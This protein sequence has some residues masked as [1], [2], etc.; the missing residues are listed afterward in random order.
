MLDTIREVATP[1]GCTLSLRLAGPVTRASAWLLDFVIRSFLF[2]AIMESLAVA[3]IASGAGGVLI[4]FV[5]EWIYPV[6]FEVYWRG[7]TPGKKVCN[8]LVLLDDGTPVG[9][10][11]SVVRNMLRAVD[12][13]PFLYGLGLISMLLNRDFK[14]LGDLAAGTIVVY[15]DDPPKLP[16]ADPYAVA[17]PSPVLLTLS[18]QRAIIEFV[19][20]SPGLTIERSEEL[21]A[22]AGPLFFFE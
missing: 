13:L 3:K 14:R 12:M 15:R 18:E 7:A 2:S 19:R 16:V 11:G 9:W 17:M 21:A 6:L 10:G 22:F 4:W 20:R 8:L 1:E 5:L